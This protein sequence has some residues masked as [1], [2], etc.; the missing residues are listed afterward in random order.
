MKWRAACGFLA[1]FL[2]VGC[3]EPPP[4]PPARQAERP[5]PP[6]IATSPD[7]K[8]AAFIRDFRDDAIKAGVRATT[9]DRSMAGISRLPRVEELNRK[10]PEFTKSPWAYLEGTVSPARVETGTALIRENDAVLE[11]VEERYGVPKETLVAIWGLES[12]FG[13]EMGGFN[14]FAALATLA[15]DGPRQEFARRELIDAMKMEE[16]QQLDPRQM[17]SSWAGAFG[18]TQFVPSSFLAHAVDGDSDGRIDLWH[19]TA[20][21][22]ASAA[23]LLRTGGWQS[24]EPCYREVTLPKGFPYE[25][26]DIDTE[27]PASAWSGMGVAPMRGN[28]LAANNSVAGIYLP[29]GW[30]GPAFIVFQNFKAVLT[31]NN[32]ATYAL[33]VCNLADRL[34]G[35]GTIVAQWPRDQRPLGPDERVAMQSDLKR[36]GYDPGDI[37]GVLGRK[38]RG[39]LRRYQ[40]DHGIPADG[41]PNP[42]M[43]GRLNDDIRSR[44]S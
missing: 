39:A 41:Y 44:A 12:G 1:A 10:Q 3:A 33:A 15:Y 30:R 25:L 16:Q 27:K 43:L 2:L 24:G 40:K 14:I 32:A 7:A 38:A 9:Y 22:L 35:G 6:Q 42:E 13:H 23:V 5:R 18:Q 37:D 29:A 20:D 8:F 11:R 17:T 26:A 19:S 21:A 34:R 4:A 36:L 31:Y 28:S